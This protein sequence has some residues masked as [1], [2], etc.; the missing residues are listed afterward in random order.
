MNRSASGQ[1]M[2]WFRPLVPPGAQRELAWFAGAPLRI[3]RDLIGDP[4]VET[5]GM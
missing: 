4:H 3:A 5:A 1:N 2:P